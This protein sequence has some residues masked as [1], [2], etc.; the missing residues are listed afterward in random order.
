MPAYSFPKKYKSLLQ[1]MYNPKDI[2]WDYIDRQLEYLE[3]FHYEWD[4]SYVTPNASF[5]YCTNPKV[6][7]DLIKI[8]DELKIGIVCDEMTFNE[9]SKKLCKDLE[10]YIKRFEPL[11]CN[12]KREDH[13]NQGRLNQY[14]S[15]FIKKD[16]YF[17][18]E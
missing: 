5:I 8:N 1:T 3:K 11:V 16:L 15:K 13:F 6:M 14:I 18:H 12:A 17:I 10:G 7:D 2:N 4:D 9:Y